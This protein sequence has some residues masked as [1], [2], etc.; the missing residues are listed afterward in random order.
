M[1]PIWR[2]FHVLSA[3]ETGNADV[4]SADVR[5]YD[6]TGEWV[7]TMHLPPDLTPKN[8]AHDIRVALQSGSKG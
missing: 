7:S 1:R 2:A 3:A 6:R 8:L 4:H 5:V